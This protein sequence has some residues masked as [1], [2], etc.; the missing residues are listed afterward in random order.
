MLVNKALLFSI[1]EAGLVIGD[2]HRGAR[3]NCISHVPYFANDGAR[4]FALCQCFHRE[5]TRHGQHKQTKASCPRH[6]FLTHLP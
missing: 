3:H 5:E 6:E 2:R 4:G 1:Y